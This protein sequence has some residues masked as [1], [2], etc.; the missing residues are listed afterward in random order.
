MHDSFGVI[1][2]PLPSLSMY[3]C[4]YEQVGMMLRKLKVQHPLT[5]GLKN[6]KKVLVAKRLDEAL[7]TSKVHPACLLARVGG[8]RRGQVV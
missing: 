8:M 7:Q 2:D 1:L 5:S 4:G 3:S 6:T